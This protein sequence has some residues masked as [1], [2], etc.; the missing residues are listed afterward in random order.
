MIWTL[1]DSIFGKK[2]FGD[3]SLKKTENKNKFLDKREVWFYILYYENVFPKEQNMGDPML[4]T[5]SLDVAEG[6]LCMA[7]QAEQKLW[8]WPLP[9][10]ASSALRNPCPLLPEMNVLRLSL[11][12]QSLCNISLASP[13]IFSLC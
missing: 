7:E 9:V 10:H 8:P 13:Q 4:Q 11:I 12:R 3:F 1:L 5:I 2:S 6:V